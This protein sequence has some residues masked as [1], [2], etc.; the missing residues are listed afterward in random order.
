MHLLTPA[1]GLGPDPRFQWRRPVYIDDPHGLIRAIAWRRP[2]SWYYFPI[3]IY[4]VKQ[5][6]M[7]VRNSPTNFV[8]LARRCC[9][10]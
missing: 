4:Q 10:C 1:P 2:V 6:V 8:Q 9:L 7:S 5:V 3:L